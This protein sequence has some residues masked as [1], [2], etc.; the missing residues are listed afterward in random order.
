MIRHHEQALLAQAQ[1]LGFLRRRCH[2][3]G[4]ASPYTMCQQ[5]ITA[6][7]DVRDSIDLVLSQCDFR[8]HSHEVDMAAVIL[9]RTLAVEFFIVQ[10]AQ[11]FPAFWIF[12]YPIQKRLLDE[13]LL[14]LRDGGLFFVKDGISVLV[15]VEDPH[16]PQV[17]R[18]LHDL[19][20]VDA[21]RAVGVVCPDVPLIRRLSL[22]VPFTGMLRVM[23]MDFP[24]RVG[25]RP[26]QLINKLLHN[27]RGNPCRAKPHRDFAHS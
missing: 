17:Q 2:F 1:P 9:S 5:C 10:S 6:I 15:I 18:F 7:E 26:E 12:P 22:H 24:A 4:F 25:R 21:I 14:C 3:V 13:R 23:H 27:V 16:I 20:A 8:V 11:A 19:V